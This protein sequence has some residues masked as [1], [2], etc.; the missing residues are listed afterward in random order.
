M[1]KIGLYSEISQRLK[2]FTG[3]ALETRKGDWGEGFSLH[4]RL[5][6]CCVVAQ[7]LHVTPYPHPLIDISKIKNRI[8]K[9]RPLYKKKLNPFHSCHTCLSRFNLSRKT[10]IFLTNISIRK[11][12]RKK[13]SCT[14]PRTN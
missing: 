4:S 13:S 5:Q 1:S 10:P 7:L 9:N 2:R 3:Y 12:E 8:T 6:K 11:E 14:A